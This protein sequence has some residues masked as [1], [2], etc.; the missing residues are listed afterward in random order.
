MDFTKKISLEE[1]SGKLY[2]I[3]SKEPENNKEAVLTH[4]L[5]DYLNG[6]EK[7]ILGVSLKGRAFRSNLFIRSSQKGFSL[8]SLTQNAS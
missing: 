1:I 8:Q 3:K 6:V 5:H 2:K 7:Y 4:Y